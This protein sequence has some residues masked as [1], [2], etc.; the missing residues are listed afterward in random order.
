[1][2]LAASRFAGFGAETPWRTTYKPER[3]KQPGHSKRGNANG[4]T[5]AGFRERSGATGLAGM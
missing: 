3:A 2:D 1:M 5:Q 4:A